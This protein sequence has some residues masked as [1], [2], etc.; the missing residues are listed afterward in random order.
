MATILGWV[1]FRDLPDGLAAAGIALTI[2]AGL[3]IIW[4]E[5]V[6][7]RVARTISA[8]PPMDP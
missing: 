8:S 7:S 2:G 4:R 5:Q 3:F 1:F 6:S